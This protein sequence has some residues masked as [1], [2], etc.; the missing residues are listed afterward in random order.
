MRLRYH[1][2]LRNLSPTTDELWGDDMGRSV[3]RAIGSVGWVG[4]LGR[5]GRSGRSV[6]GVNRV[7]RVGR[8]V[9]GYMKLRYHR[10]QSLAA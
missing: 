8:S 4:R 10:A 3:A 6:G 5:F 7:G 2:A 1:R 9:V